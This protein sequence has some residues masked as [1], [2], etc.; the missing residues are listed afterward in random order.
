MPAGIGGDHVEAKGQLAFGD[1][2]GLGGLLSGGLGLLGRGFG[3]HS[4]GGGLFGRL[5]GLGILD[6]HDGRAAG[7]KAQAEHERK[8]DG[9]HFLHF[10]F[11]PY[12]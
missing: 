8:R 6:H 7:G 12:Q 10:V 4:G 2:D 5:F 3:L 9:K 11:L 1:L